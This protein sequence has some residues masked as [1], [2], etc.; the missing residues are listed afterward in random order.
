MIEKTVIFDTQVE[1]DT[2]V[3]LDLA[4]Y[5]ENHNDVGYV[6]SKWDTPRQRIDGKWDYLACEDQ[7]Y[8]GFTLEDF[9]LSNY[10]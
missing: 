10:A 2:Q 3:A 9:D 5:L 1:A 8:T 6:C 4:K 7:D